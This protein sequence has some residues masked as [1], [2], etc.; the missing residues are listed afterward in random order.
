MY[1]PLKFIID[2]IYIGWISDSIGTGIS[3]HKILKRTDREGYRKFRVK[4][5]TLMAV[6]VSILFL[7]ASI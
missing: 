2:T 5:L 6:L 3:I 4:T 1:G 7:I